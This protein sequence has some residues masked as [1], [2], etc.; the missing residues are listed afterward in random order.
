MV[1]AAG[2]TQFSFRLLA[3]DG[4]ARRG[5]IATAHGTIQTPVFMPVGTAASVKSLTTEQLERLG[6]EIILNN[7]YH[8]MLR[9]GIDLLDRLGISVDRDEKSSCDENSHE[10]E[11]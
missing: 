8:L 3:T 6:P 7:T 5:E 1:H 10:V 4:E 11:W 2:M 9:P